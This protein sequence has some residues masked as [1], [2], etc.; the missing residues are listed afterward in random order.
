M[1]SG[2]D[3]RTLEQIK[4]RIAEINRLK[5]EGK[6]LTQEELE[7]YQELGEKLEKIQETTEN[8]IKSFKEEPAFMIIFFIYSKYSVKWII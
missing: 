2:D 8:R 1:A 3:I 6:T 5:R 4:A 7:E